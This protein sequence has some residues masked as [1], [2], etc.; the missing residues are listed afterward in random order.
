[1][2]NEQAFNIFAIFWGVF[3]IVFILLIATKKIILKK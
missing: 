1:M 3:L 2:I